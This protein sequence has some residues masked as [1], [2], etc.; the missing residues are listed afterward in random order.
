MLTV[1]GNKMFKSK[2]TFITADVFVNLHTRD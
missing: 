1:N 2:G